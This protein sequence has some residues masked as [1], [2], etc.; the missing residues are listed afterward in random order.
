M[1]SPHAYPCRQE[2][3]P[4]AAQ[5]SLSAL[6]IDLVVALAQRPAGVGAGELAR[7]VR[8]APTSVQNGLRLLAAHG[9][10]LRGASRYA[11][12]PGHPAAA[13]LVALGLRLVAP[14][15]AIGLVLRAC[16]SV[17]FA[18]VDLTG[19]VVGTRP[20]ASS[21]SMAILESSLATIRR[22]RE[23]VP[24]V[25]RFDSDELTRILRSAIGLRLRVM[26]A[27]IL[28]GTVRPVGPS[29]ATAYPR[30]P[31]STPQNS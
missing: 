25:L 29:A 16:D 21:E 28:K 3:A 18:S 13:E 24:V 17:E 19:F 8:G 5:L 6:S 27:T 15:A 26:T 2:G 4:I 22:D 10:V 9:L 31:G 1:R 14:E 23:N 11:F 12:V 7:I 20:D 30:G